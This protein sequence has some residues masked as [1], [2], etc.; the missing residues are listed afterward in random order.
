MDI[1]DEKKTIYRPA[2]RSGMGIWNYYV[3]TLTMAQISEY[4]KMPDEIYQSE[5][6]SEHL[7]RTLT[8]NAK[9]IYEYLKKEDE[10][11]FNAL[12]LA[13][14]D[15]NPQWHEGVFM[16]GSHE[17][18]NIGVLELTGEEK[19]F[20]VD[21]Q[22]R[23]AAIKE[24]VAKKEANSEEEVPVIYIAH[25]NDTKG[26]RRTRRLFTTLNRYAKPVKLNEIIALDEDDLVAI[27]TRRLVEDNALFGKDRLAYTKTESISKN[28]KKSLSTIITLYHCNCDLLSAFIFDNQMPKKNYQRYRETDEIIDEFEKYI[29]QFWNTLI[30]KIPD[31]DNYMRK[32]PDTTL[33]R[34]EAGGNMLFR[35]AGLKAFVEATVEIHLATKDSFEKI[36]DKLSKMDLNLSSSPWQSV[37]WNNGKMIMNNKKLVKQMLFY[38]YN[39][40][41]KNVKGKSLVDEEWM[42]EEYK[43]LLGNDLRLIEIKRLIKQQRK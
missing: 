14:Y 33:F 10:R 22:H 16:M 20:P 27:N 2:I 38:Y 7:Q 35:P 15:G 36:F 34:T 29:L 25:I 24:L 13:V 40:N 28:D 18:T 32:N 43:S 26:I 19:V 6:I 39:E 17:F 11:F 9:A 37:L 8:D 4:V 12:V 3:S 42:F 41:M 5:K 21:G 30:K 31:L 1:K 23:V